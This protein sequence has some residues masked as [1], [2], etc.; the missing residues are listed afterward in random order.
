MPITQ[1]HRAIRV[2]SEKLYPEIKSIYH[3][4]A[5]YLKWKQELPQN[6]EVLHLRTHIQ[7]HQKNIVA[8]FF[9]PHRKIPYDRRESAV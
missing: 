3:T 7:V 2:T 6:L 5:L 4:N 9:I 1:E 8:T